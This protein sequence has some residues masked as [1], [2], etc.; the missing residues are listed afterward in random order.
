MQQILLVMEGNADQAWGWV[1]QDNVWMLGVLM[2]CSAMT[3]T[4]NN[5]HF[6]YR[7]LVK[8]FRLR[9]GMIGLFYKKSPPSARVPRPCTPGK[10][11]NLMAN[12][13]DKMT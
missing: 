5:V 4:F 12:D 1:T 3:W 13:A 7:M 11:T 10:I 8:S 6:N 2:F 9:A